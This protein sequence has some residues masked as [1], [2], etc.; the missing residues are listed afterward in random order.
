MNTF[1]NSNVALEKAVIALI[2]N[3]KNAAGN[4]EHFGF[5]IMDL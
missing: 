2:E 5:L 3:W 4:G 1:P